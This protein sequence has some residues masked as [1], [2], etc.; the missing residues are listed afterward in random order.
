MLMVDISESLQQMCWFAGIRRIVINMSINLIQQLA[1]VMCLMAL[2]GYTEF[3]MGHK[4]NSTQVGLEDM[5]PSLSLS[6][7]LSL[8]EQNC[9]VFFFTCRGC[10]NSERSKSL[11]VVNSSWPFF[12]P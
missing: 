4:I 5:E 11:C 8:T 7:S 2:E 3:H 12:L 1:H 9:Q 10:L 6:L